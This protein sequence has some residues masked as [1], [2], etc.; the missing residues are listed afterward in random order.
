MQFSIQK[1]IYARS[2]F[3]V[4]QKSILKFDNFFEFANIKFIEIFKPYMTSQNDVLLDI[5]YFYFL[6]SVLG[7]HFQSEIQIGITLINFRMN[8]S[9]QVRFSAISFSR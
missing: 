2:I 3:V 7:K 9:F 1:T 5:I 4:S 8:R 6:K